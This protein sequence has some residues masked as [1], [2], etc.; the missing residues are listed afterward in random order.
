M[1][2]GCVS[3]DVITCIHIGGLGASN[4]ALGSGELEDELA[5]AELFG[6]FGEVLEVTLRLRREGG[7]V[8]WA[9]LSYG[10]ADEAQVKQNPPPQTLSNPSARP[11]RGIRSGC[12]ARIFWDVLG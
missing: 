5:L 7:K 10:S 12:S 1:T 2:A 9:L 11:G 3:A 6:Q 4:S 8:S